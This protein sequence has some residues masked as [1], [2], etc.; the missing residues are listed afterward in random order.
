MTL[1]GTYIPKHLE[2]TGNSARAAPPPLLHT[3]NRWRVQSSASCWPKAV[4]ITFLTAHQDECTILAA[5]PLEQNE[6]ACTSMH[7]SCQ[8]SPQLVPYNRLALNKLYLITRA[9]ISLCN[10]HY[11]TYQTRM[12]CE[13]Q[14][15]RSTK[16]LAV[17][18]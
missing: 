11:S 6:R 3:L 4:H 7:C 1:S 15:S 8:F 17:G 18:K 13:S 5:E 16:R 14:G 12:P 2:S 10:L 9:E